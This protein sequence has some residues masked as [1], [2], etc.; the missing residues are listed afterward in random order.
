LG[1]RFG[2]NYVLWFSILGA[3]PFALLLPHASLAWTTP[4]AMVIG[5]ILASAFPAIIVFAQELMPDN[6]GTV[7]GL[8]F[9]FA[10]GVGGIGA[11]AL[12]WAADKVGIETVYHWV[13]FMPA[14]G[15]LCLFLPRIERPAQV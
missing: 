14:L 12:G 10:F 15:L 2:R 8:F 7:S 1:D 4:L 6:V 3:L 5:L 9:G 13:A 11:A